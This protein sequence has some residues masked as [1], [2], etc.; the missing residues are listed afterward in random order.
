MDQYI[1][2]IGGLMFTL[3]AAVC[4]LVRK[5]LIPLAIGTGL[6]TIPASFSEILISRDYWQPPVVFGSSTLSLEDFVF[7]LGIIAFAA[8]MYPV[9]SGS[10]FSA[11]VHKPRLKV[12][13]L[14]VAISIVALLV[15][16]FGLGVNTVVLLA[17][18][19]AVFTPVMWKLR[20]DLIKPS[21]ACAVGATL[22]MVA[23]Y[24]V[25]FNYLAPEWW[26]RYWLL[27]DTRL[28]VTVLGN[29]PI[30]EMAWYF[31]WF[32]FASISFPFVEGRS[33]VPR[34]KGAKIDPFKPVL[35]LFKRKA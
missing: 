23:M 25:F 29:V 32:L 24:I 5:D 10:S 16:S 21:L 1:Y 22:L 12:Y 9:L 11:V 15:L 28:G 31:F 4:C 7:N 18:L 20:P 6:F 13:G 8:L 26:D 14:F 2:L 19:F 33:V 17:A 34:A 3:L 27:A 35:S 30:T